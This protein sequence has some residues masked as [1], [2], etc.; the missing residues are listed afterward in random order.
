MWQKTD[1]GVRAE[2]SSAPL[3]KIFMTN[4]T[5]E[6]LKELLLDLQSQ[7]YDATYE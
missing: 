4:E 1:D 5:Q 6:Q 7:D 2:S 3:Q